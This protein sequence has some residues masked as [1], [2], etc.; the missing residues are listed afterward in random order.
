MKP[1]DFESLLLLLTFF[2]VNGQFT[3]Y[4][5]QVCPSFCLPGEVMVTLLTHCRT[6]Y[7]KPYFAISVPPNP[8]CHLQNNVTA[9]NGQINK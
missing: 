5:L 2:F 9:K 6:V 4:W 7:P 1:S 3:T 8:I